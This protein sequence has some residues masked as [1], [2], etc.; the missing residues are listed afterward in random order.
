MSQRKRN[1]EFSRPDEPSFLK[2]LKNQIGYQN[3][4]VTI[5]TKVLKFNFKFKD[6]IISI[7]SCV[8]LE[9]K[10]IQKRFGLS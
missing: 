8:I 4:E 7:F 6:K 2:K 3:N 5:E 9:R 10:T 1:I